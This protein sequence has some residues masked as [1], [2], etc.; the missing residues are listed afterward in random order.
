VLARAASHNHNVQHMKRKFLKD[1][2]SIHKLTNIRFL[3]HLVRFEHK[4]NLKMNENILLLAQ[5]NHIL[6]I[7][8]KNKAIYQELVELQTRIIKNI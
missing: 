8:G 2:F 7:L 4:Y 6:E 3:T 5:F 1:R